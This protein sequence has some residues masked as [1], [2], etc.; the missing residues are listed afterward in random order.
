MSDWT[1]LRAARVTATALEGGAFPRATTEAAGTK[2]PRRGNGGESS[3]SLKEL[4]PPDLDLASS[5]GVTGI[6]TND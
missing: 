5:G 1:G 4:S 2:E 3:G 6:P